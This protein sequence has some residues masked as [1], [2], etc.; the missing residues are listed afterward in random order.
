MCD[1]IECTHSPQ[2]MD[3]DGFEMWRHEK[4]KK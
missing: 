4:F 3:A 2:S 1:K